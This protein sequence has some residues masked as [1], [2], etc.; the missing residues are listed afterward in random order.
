MP[1][2]K[3]TSLAMMGGCE[4]GEAILREASLISPIDDEQFR[5]DVKAGEL[6]VGTCPT[7]EGRPHALEDAEEFACPLQDPAGEG[8]RILRSVLKVEL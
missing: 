2:P 7:C 3:K 6:I 1:E 5:A 4:N 8:P